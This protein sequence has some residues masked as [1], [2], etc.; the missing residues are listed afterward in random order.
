MIGSYV[1]FAPF[2]QAIAAAVKAAK[3]A[4]YTHLYYPEMR[5][6]HEATKQMDVWFW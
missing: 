2:D 4:A 3:F 1:M 5:T 6:A